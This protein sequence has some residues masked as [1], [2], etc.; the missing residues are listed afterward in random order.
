MAGGKGESVTQPL[1]AGDRLFFVSDRTDF[2]N[3]Y[4]EDASGQVRNCSGKLVLCYKSG[5]PV[6]R[7][8]MRNEE[9]HALTLCVCSSYPALAGVVACQWCKLR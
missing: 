1:W 8:S 6:K 7:N 2:W 5:V 9:L 3:I 4:S